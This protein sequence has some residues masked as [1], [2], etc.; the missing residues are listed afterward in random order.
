MVGKP[1]SIELV[2]TNPLDDGQY[3]L[4]ESISKG[5]YFLN[6]TDINGKVHTIKL[7]KE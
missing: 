4:S 2:K 7:I 6:I 1:V 3:L 5:V